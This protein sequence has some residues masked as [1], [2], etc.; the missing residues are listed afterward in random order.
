MENI[1]LREN[2]ALL[3]KVVFNKIRIKGITN[4]EELQRREIIEV[5]EKSKVNYIMESGQEFTKLKL[6]GD[7]LVDRME[8]R[9]T[10]F[11]NDKRDSCVLETTVKDE[12]GTNLN[13]YTV[14][15]YAERLKKIQDRLMRVYGVDTDF[16]QIAIKEIEINRTFKL[17]KDFQDYHRPITLIIDNLP[18]IFREQMEFSD[19]EKKG[20]ELDRAKST[21][22]YYARTGNGKR[23]HSPKY[24]LFKIY[25]KTRSVEKSIE[26]T[27]SYM[28]VEIRLIGA[29]KV[30]RSL[31][32]N[33]FGELTDEIINQYFDGQIQEMIVSPYEKWK[34]E[35]DKRILEIMREQMRKA[36]KHW[37]VNTLRV[38]Q[39]KEVRRYS[40]MLLDVSELMPL[41]DQLIDDRKTRYSVKTQ[42]RNQARKYESAF[43]NDDDKKLQELLYKMR[44][45]EEG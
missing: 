16:S 21:G 26:L 29:E 7:E 10:I 28:R 33:L 13:C 1:I 4:F 41:V 20:K 37:I 44:T 19:R 34:R 2:T 25:D 3:D 18:P 15:Q 43:C 6:I 9:S 45:K 31:G 14:G 39:D 38:L 24:L 11:G 40:P 22:T 17:N 35:R 42:F 8:A 32:T 5:K 23:T 30:R 36:P 12:N 27:E